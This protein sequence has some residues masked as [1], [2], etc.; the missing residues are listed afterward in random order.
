MNPFDSG[1]TLPCPT[2]GEG[3]TRVP[4]PSFR[5]PFYTRVD[6]HVSEHEC[7]TW[8]ATCTDAKVDHVLGDNPVCGKQRE[9]VTTTCQLSSLSG[10]W[11]CWLVGDRTDPRVRGVGSTGGTGILCGYRGDDRFLGVTNGAGRPLTFDEAGRPCREGQTTVPRDPTDVGVSCGG[12]RGT[13]LIL[14]RIRPGPRSLVREGRSVS[15]PIWG[16]FLSGDQ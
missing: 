13:S 8:S 6:T 10:D 5:S 16:V 2:T 14:S 12:F 11:V 4:S 1:S 3:V 7:G 9:F 15:G